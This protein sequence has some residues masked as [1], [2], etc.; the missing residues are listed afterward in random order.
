MWLRGGCESAAAARRAG[1]SGGS[2]DGSCRDCLS[3]FSLVASTHG[4][5]HHSGSSRKSHEQNRRKHSWGTRG[6]GWVCYAH[7][8]R[9]TLV[10]VQLTPALLTSLVP[11][12]AGLTPPEFCVVLLS[13]STAKSCLQDPNH[14]FFGSLC[15]KFVRSHHALLTPFTPALTQQRSKWASKIHNKAEGNNNSNKKI[16]LKDKKKII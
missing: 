9:V 15:K 4:P 12:A 3:L 16:K 10:D 6:T 7:S 14:H 13:V 1:V 8:H 11:G 2:W 5:C